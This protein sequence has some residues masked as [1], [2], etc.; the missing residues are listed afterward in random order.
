MIYPIPDY[1]LTS[2]GI[3][4]TLDLSGSLIFGPD[5]QYIKDS[6]DYSFPN[7]LKQVELLEKFYNSVSKYLKGVDKDKLSLDYTGIRP[8]LSGENQGFQDFVIEKE[9]EG[10]INLLGIESPGLTS[11]L[12]ISEFVRDLI[13][14]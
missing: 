10:F 9:Q 14:K 2:L 13:Y 5:V 7:G 12:A 6:D 4:C 1:N 11:C 8:K 3:H